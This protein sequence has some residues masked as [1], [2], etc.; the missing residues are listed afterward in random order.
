MFNWFRRQKEEPTPSRARSI[1]S[2]HV[3][4]GSAR[5]LVGAG[6]VLNFILSKHPKA[7]AG[8]AQD[9]AGGDSGLK[10]QFNGWGS[11]NEAQLNWYA[12]QGFIGYQ[13][14]ALLTQNWLIN[15]AC[16]IPARD[17]TRNG[18]EVVTVDGSELSK[19][20]EAVIKKYDKKFKLRWN[21]E[22]FVR[23]GRIFGIRIAV[24][25]VESTDPEY[26][27]KPFNIDGVTPGSYKGITQ[28]DPYWVVPEVT[29]V[30]NPGDQHFYE[31]LYWRVGGRRYHRSHLAIF[32][33]MEVADLL[34]PA[35]LYGGMPVP[36]LIME[37]VYAAERTANEGPLLA[38][39][40]RLRHVT[41][42]DESMVAAGDDVLA[43]VG[44]MNEMANNHGVWLGMEG[45]QFQQFETSLG[46]LDNT[47]MNQ[48]QLV[49]AASNV[50]ATKLLGTSPKGFN[51]TGEYEEANYHEE[52]ESLQ[53]HDLTAFVERHH[54]L[55]LRSYCPDDEVETTVTWN[56]TDTPTAEELA[57]LNS[58]KG[59]TDKGY[60]EAGV[61]QPEEVRRRLATDRDSGYNTLGHDDE[62][63]E[64][65]R[66]LG[67]DD[68]AV[69]AAIELGITG[70]AGQ[71]G[72]G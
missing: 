20:A 45:D 49:A 9:N 57:E 44:R 14:C 27:E 7:A 72:P 33:N 37:R 38:M 68:E 12:S 32:R 55:V 51:A 50:P 63:E 60:I 11:L 5:P 36:Q 1:F 69:A 21:A 35:Y 54:A 40:K 47:I 53:E 65:L 19:E 61:L 13:V 59:Q 39:S 31:P 22:Q 34:K 26:Y 29:N 6:D 15:K 2:T 25:N 10:A 64:V 3:A 58:K 48:Y 30:S 46:D 24:F 42:T 28:V 18:F 66:D 23:F 70:G 4:D 17:A 67:L 71:P 62:D 43:R 56:P 41:T 52:L 8:T 16:S